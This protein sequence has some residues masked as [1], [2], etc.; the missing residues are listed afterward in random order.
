MAHYIAIWP[1]ERTR[2]DCQF[3]WI[4]FPPKE[5]SAAFVPWDKRPL[6]NALTPINLTTSKERTIWVLSPWRHLGWNCRFETVSLN[7]DYIILHKKHE[8]DHCLTT[9][10][11]LRFWTIGTWSIF[12]RSRILNLSRSVRAID[13]LVSF[14]ARKES[15]GGGDW[16][17]D[18]WP[19]DRSWNE[20]CTN[21]KSTCHT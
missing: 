14:Y 18:S 6:E 2:M 20:P 11:I 16:E 1:F 17:R 10:R 9:S 5:P 8:K 15:N 21:A 3:Q 19:R 12:C 13:E 4:R 7:R